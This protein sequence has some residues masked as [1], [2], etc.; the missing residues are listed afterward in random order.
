MA[1]ENKAPLFGFG[2]FGRMP[3]FDF[4]KLM[5]DLK[6]P[7][8]DL[9]T[10]MEREK[11]NIEALTEANRVAFEGWQ[12]LVHRQTEILQDSIK[13]GVATARGA[14][15]GTQRLDPAAARFQ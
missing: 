10:I 3:S 4:M 14:D 9:A 6:L 13:R 2:D 11:K 12:A 7:G 8:V 15:G 5:K 1:D